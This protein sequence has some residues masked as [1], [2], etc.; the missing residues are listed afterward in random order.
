M[1]YDYQPPPAFDLVRWNNILTIHK[2]YEHPNLDKDSCSICAWVRA[3]GDTT[4]PVKQAIGTKPDHPVTPEQRDKFEQRYVTMLQF[5]KM[6]RLQLS[7]LMEILKQLGDRTGVVYLVTNAEFKSLGLE[8][9]RTLLNDAVMAVQPKMEVERMPYT[10]LEIESKGGAVTKVKIDG[11]QFEGWSKLT[12][13][14]QKG[15]PVRV[16]A[17]VPDNR[18]APDDDHDAPELDVQWNGTTVQADTHARACGGRVDYTD[19]ET[20]AVCG[21]CPRCHARVAERVPM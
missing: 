21:Y 15:Y 17:I 10:S 7:A 2:K 16:K 3:H 19:C 14:L 1:S 11:K 8:E 13:E 20:H 5:D 12:L 9:L 6:D 4:D 18:V